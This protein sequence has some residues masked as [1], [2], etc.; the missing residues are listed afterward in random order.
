MKKKKGKLKL[1]IHKMLV[2]IVKPE[3]YRVDIHVHMD[4]I[5]TYT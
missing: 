5:T 1:N 3:I 4:I 2:C